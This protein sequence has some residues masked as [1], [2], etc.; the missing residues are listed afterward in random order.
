VSLE[1]TTLFAAR[2]SG[3]FSVPPGDFARP[4]LVDR[5]FLERSVLA[6]QDMPDAERQ[7]R[8]G[9]AERRDSIHALD[10]VYRNELNA[11]AAATRERLWLE[12]FTAH[13]IL[14]ALRGQNPRPPSTVAARHTHPKSNDPCQGVL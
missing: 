5:G 3:P 11:W 13:A 1:Q 6:M 14:D 9:M 8:D 12:Y 2:P 10:L 7:L 4:G